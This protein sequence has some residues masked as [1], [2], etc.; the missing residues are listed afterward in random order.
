MFEFLI[1]SL[2]LFVFKRLSFVRL[3]L[4]TSSPS[5]SPLLKIRVNRV[6][7]SGFSQLTLTGL[8]VSV[9]FR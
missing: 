7:G 4:S 1:L 9:F 3:E 5:T 2:S 6:N 8:R